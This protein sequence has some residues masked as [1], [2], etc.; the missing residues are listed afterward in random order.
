M[1][2]EPHDPSA[3]SDQDLYLWNEGTHFRLYDKLGAHIEDGRTRFAVWAPNAGSVSVVGDWNGWDPKADPM[4]PLGVSG[5]WE[6]AVATDLAQSA[7]KYH[8]VNGGYSVDKADPFGFH[9]ET[10]PHTASKVWSLD[11]DWQDGAW[12]RRT[13]APRRPS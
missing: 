4:E 1:T 10:P 6:L 7:Y 11:Y 3:F 9:H 12:M 2:K 5:I 8:I 13:R